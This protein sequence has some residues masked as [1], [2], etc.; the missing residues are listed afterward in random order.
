MAVRAVP[1]YDTFMESLKVDSSLSNEQLIADMTAV[2]DAL[3]TNI[4]VIS[5]FYS[6]RKLEF[7]GTV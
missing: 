7:E 6:T 3:K 1:Y 2:I 5:D 4:D